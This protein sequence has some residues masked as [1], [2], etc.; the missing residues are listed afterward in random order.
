MLASALHSLVVVECHTGDALSR[1]SVGAAESPPLLDVLLEGTATSLGWDA[2]GPRVAVAVAGGSTDRVRFF[3]VA[4]GGKSAASEDV[5]LPAGAG[6]TDV[7]VCCVHDQNKTWAAVSCTDGAL[8]LIDASPGRAASVVRTSYSHGVAATAV[9]LSMDG[10]IIAS[11][12]ASGHVV[13]QPFQGSPGLSPLPG[14]AEASEAP[15]AGLR[16]SPLRQDVLAACD[17]AGNLQDGQA[18]YPAAVCGAFQCLSVGRMWVSRV[19]GGGVRWLL[20]ASLKG[21]GEAF[22]RLRCEAAVCGCFPY[23]TLAIEGGEWAVYPA[24]DEPDE[25]AGP[26]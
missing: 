19:P 20:V 11:G 8:R 9:E 23:L 16:F 25:Q 7:S 18:G 2:L 1:G 22:I 4:P 21:V 3:R 26:G 15:I 14:L 6:A 5:A 17:E 10:R 12:S 24:A 13:V